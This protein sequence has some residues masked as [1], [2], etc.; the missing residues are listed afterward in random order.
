MQGK[1]AE[2]VVFN[3]RL[4][5]GS[6]LCQEDTRVVSCVVRIPRQFVLYTMTCT[7]AG[8]EGALLCSV[9]WCTDCPQ[10]LL[11]RTG[12]GR[13]LQ[14]LLSKANNTSRALYLSAMATGWCCVTGSGLDGG[15]ISFAL[16]HGGTLIIVP[17]SAA[18]LSC[19]TTR[20]ILQVRYFQP[21]VALTLAA[22]RLSLI[23]TNERGG[24]RSKHLK[25]RCWLIAGRANRSKKK[26]RKVASTRYHRN[27]R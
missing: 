22:F 4:L 27:R 11:Y 6:R 10:S 1:D 5:S 8:G 24:K 2:C 14:F 9:L 12:S 15:K 25:I 23:K 3:R 7:C 20:E 18:N 17:R 26:T 13:Q 19:R 16:A 21:T